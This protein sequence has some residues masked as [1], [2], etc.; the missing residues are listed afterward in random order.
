MNPN[1]PYPDATAPLATGPLLGSPNK[2]KLAVFCANVQR[3]TTQSFVGETLKATWADSMAVV[4]AADEAGIEAI[5]PLA[6]WRKAV[7]TVPE[8]DR[9]FETFT[10]AAAV[11]AVT[12]R[13]QIFATV[14]IPL[15]HPVMAAK[16]AATVDH[17]SG[18]RF[19][20]NVV[21]G[22]NTHDFNMFGY[23]QREHDDR[24]A[25]AAEWMALVQ[26]LWTEDE[27]FDFTGQFY[28]GT[29]IVSEPKPVQAP[30][31]VIMS[32][33]SSPAGQAFAQAHADINFAV[34]KSI[35]DAPKV[36]AAAR[37][38]AKA[39]GRTTQ[40]FG[41]AWIVCRDTEEEAKAYFDHVIRQHGDRSGAEATVNEMLASGSRSIDV[42]A[43]EAMVERS[44]GGFFALQLV[45]T[46]EQIVAK[47]KSL[48]DAGLDG[49]AISWVD[50]EA[51]LKHYTER[52][53]PLLIAAG[54]RVQ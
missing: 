33:G 35:D 25:V 31:P 49:L 45:G 4:R 48:S 39:A 5:I 53:L 37:E 32:A 52:L 50:Y 1:K 6:R 21:A 30:R 11:A 38:S 27:P 54:L 3:G 46:A 41:A 26:R 36:V 44:M 9:I 51:G 28:N 47:M 18:G 42:I 13:A 19:A 40:I 7:F 14:H 15:V 8:A 22:W 34:V 12:R 43:R 20:M 10:W 29:G 23:V 17:I 2:L 24:Y 16:A